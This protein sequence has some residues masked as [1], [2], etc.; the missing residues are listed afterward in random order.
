MKLKLL[1]FFVLVT[2]LHADGVHKIPKSG[3]EQ[4]R[5][6]NGLL[7]G[8]TINVVK[9]EYYEK[10]FYPKARVL[11][12]YPGAS[13][14]VIGGL[15]D[16]LFRTNK[17]WYLGTI[18]KVD[19]SKKCNLFVIYDDGDQSWVPCAWAFPYTPFSGM[20]KAE[21]DSFLAKPVLARFYDS[22]RNLKYW[23]LG[24]V[25]RID[26]NG[27][28]VVYQDKDTKVHTDLNTLS[29]ANFIVE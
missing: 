17:Y 29:Q 8:F 23:Y 18:T 6:E 2:G 24:T 26:P 22:G 12:K 27:Y 19:F 20:S 13:I 21:R 5:V 28:F 11:A 16:A 25:T 9:R 7:T 15:K 10:V 3:V 14:P 1:P 4:R